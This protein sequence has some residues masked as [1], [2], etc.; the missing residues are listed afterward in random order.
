MRSGASSDHYKSNWP[1]F[2]MMSFLKDL[3]IPAVKSGNLPRLDEPSQDDETTCDLEEDKD[4]ETNTRS[5]MDPTDVYSPP[6]VSASGEERP[7]SSA[8]ATSPMFQ[9]EKGKNRKRI[10]DVRDEKLIE[11]E[12]KKLNLL[13]QHLKNDAG[14][15]DCEELLFFKS[16]IPYMDK[17]NPI[18]KLKIRNKI[19]NVILDE[20]ESAEN[21]KLKISQVTRAQNNNLNILML[22][23]QNSSPHHLLPPENRISHHLLSPENPSHHHLLTSQNPSPHHSAVSPNYSTSSTPFSEPPTQQHPFQ[24]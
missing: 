17:F 23:P 1:Y 18:Q 8:S 12:N 22:S 19:Q 13:T 9:H 2:D 14:E 3:L 10:S 11:I 5:D 24:Y 6:S 7:L 15:A 4:D 16:L 21:N 20:L